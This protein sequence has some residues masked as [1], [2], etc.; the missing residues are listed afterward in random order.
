MLADLDCLDHLEALASLRAACARGDR[1]PVTVLNLAIAEDRAGDGEPA[2][3]R[4][5]GLAALLPDWDEPKLRLAES[6]RRAGDTAA[7]EQAYADVLEINPRREEAL[8]ASAALM[9]QR[10]DGT[11]AQPLLRRCV[12]VNPERAEA[13][14][15]L[16]LALMLTKEWQ[17][18]EAAFDE[19]QRVAPNVLNYALHW[20]EAAQAAGTLEAVLER[21]DRSAEADPLNPVVLTA[22]GLALERLARRNEAIDALETAS[23]LAPDAAGPAT[24]AGRLLARANRLR[25]AEA[26]LR[27][28]AELAPGDHAL[29]N[30]HAAVLTRLQRHAAARSKLET[31]L[32]QRGPDPAVLCNLAVVLVSLGRQAE[33][34]AAARQAIALKPAMPLA[35]RTL[36]NALAYRAG[37]GVAELLGAYRD[38]GERLPRASMPALTNAPDPMRKLRLGLLSGSLRGHPVGWLTIAGLET[39]DPARFEIVCLAQNAAS[40]TIA[41]RFRAIAT[42]WHDIDLLDDPALAL[43]ARERRIDV[44]IDLGGYGDSGRMPACAYRL[45]P[46][47]VKWV[48]MQTHSSGLPEM[49][50]FISDRWETPPG[51]E[52]YYSERILRLPDGYVCYSPPAYAAEVGALPAAG[53][54]FVTFGC[55]NNLAK[56]TPEV[57]GTWARILGLVPSARL[58]LKTYQF[59]EPE[60]ATRVRQAFAECG[61]GAER[62]ELRGASPHREFMA[63]YNQIDLVLD[64]FPYSGGLTTC[65][66]LWM[67]VPTVTLP[68]ETFA[69]RHSTSHLSNVGLEDWVA[70]DLDDYVKLAVTKA[71]DLESLAKLRASLRTRVKASPLC[72]APRF[73][74]NLGAALRHAWAE[75]CVA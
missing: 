20:V 34:E 33:G 55:F 54:G 26:M 14:D 50:W 13:W 60:S 2:R 72:D 9:I 64:P 25:D 17:A 38:F 56:V 71:A 21:L 11:A 58:V 36:A 35:R 59:S 15:A 3:R 19:A 46:V 22:R 63:E 40:D 12:G 23:A 51:L 65:E 4:M 28:A 75:W 8:V 6:L 1:S 44:L 69:S 18:A 74:R 27:H 67:G 70:A 31:I 45:A 10:G 39:L 5:R 30:D 53:S 61:V 49:D 24:L 42:E 73:G 68:C 47:Q 32:E 16:G 41:R 37:T 57:I 29:R 48:G 43:L 52:R 66:A 7:A 62:V